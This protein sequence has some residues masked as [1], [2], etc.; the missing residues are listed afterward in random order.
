[1]APATRGGDPRR[2]VGGPLND[3]PQLSHGRRTV[4]AVLPPEED[5]SENAGFVV[6][7]R[8]GDF[9]VLYWSCA[10]MIS[11]APHTSWIVPGAKIR[12]TIFMA[13]PHEPEPALGDNAFVRT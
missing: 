8:S 11:D 13:V 3:I 5:A 7:G 6:F 12:A 9:D 4:T 10:Y 1:M 2:L